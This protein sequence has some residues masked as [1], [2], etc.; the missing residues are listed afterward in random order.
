MFNKHVYSGVDAYYVVWEPFKLLFQT[1]APP[2]NSFHTCTCCILTVLV[3]SEI[4]TRINRAHL[5]SHISQTPH[6]QLL[7][8]A[9]TNASLHIV[10]FTWVE[11]D[12]SSKAPQFCL[13][14]LHVP[15]LWHQ[16]CE[17]SAQKR[18]RK[19]IKSEMRLIQSQATFLSLLGYGYICV[20]SDNRVPGKLRSRETIWV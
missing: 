19:W 5:K 17:H 2:H 3:P 6:L 20:T 16:F 12:Y 13:I 14:H 7:W 10:I 8:S 9:T 11:K 4:E 15:H 1:T 18:Q